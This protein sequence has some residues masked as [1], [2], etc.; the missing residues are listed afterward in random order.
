LDVIHPDYFD[1]E[2]NAGCAN[3]DGYI[4]SRFADSE[5][6][7]MVYGGQ[8][9][10]VSDY[11][12][13][14]DQG[15]KGG[16]EDWANSRYAAETVLP[17][18]FEQ[19][20]NLVLSLTGFVEDSFGG[21]G[22]SAAADFMDNL[23]A[24]IDS[25]SAYAERLTSARTEYDLRQEVDV[26]NHLGGGY[27]YVETPLGFMPIGYNYETKTAQAWLNE[28]EQQG[29]GTHAEIIKTLRGPNTDKKT[30]ILDVIGRSSLP[31][32]HDDNNDSSLQQ[33]E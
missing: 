3:A 4:Y 22:V 11:L 18:K 17:K 25:E 26:L 19:G 15:R 20:L 6:A 13:F 5:N 30:D 9:F 10:Q 8:M 31:P 33:G 27:A 24:I 23:A 14:L 1:F 21:S 12:Q 7:I 16:S 32:S 28:L 29:F 2:N